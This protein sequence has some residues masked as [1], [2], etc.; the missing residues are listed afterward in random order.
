MVSVETVLVAL[1]TVFFIYEIDKFDILLSLIF[2]LNNFFSGDFYSL[3]CR[4]NYVGGV[5]A[6]PLLLLLLSGLHSINVSTLIS[7]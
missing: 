7:G 4:D 5:L 3:A 2:F 6:Y 1:I